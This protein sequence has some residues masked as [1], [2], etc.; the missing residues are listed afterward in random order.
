MPPLVPGV[1]GRSHFCMLKD[2]GDSASESLEARARRWAFVGMR[3]KRERV[4]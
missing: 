3:E 1:L 2:W 4:K